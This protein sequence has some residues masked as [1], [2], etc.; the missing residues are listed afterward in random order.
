[1]A[2]KEARERRA[3]RQRQHQDLHERAG[4]RLQFVNFDLLRLARFQREIAGPEKIEIRAA[5]VARAAVRLRVRAIRAFEK[6]RGVAVRAELHSFRI[7]S[8]AFRAS[9]P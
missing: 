6:Q 2:K 8:A 9:H 1:M 7:R 4:F 3:G 5:T